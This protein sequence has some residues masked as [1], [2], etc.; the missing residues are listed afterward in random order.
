MTRNLK[1][2]PLGHCFNPHM[3]PV[4][5]RTRFEYDAGS[6]FEVILLADGRLDVR[7]SGAHSDMLYTQHHVGNNLIV[8]A[9]RWST[10]A[11]RHVE[12]IKP[13]PSKP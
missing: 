11:G 7:T 10:E 13:E 12:F 5:Y 2:Y 1:K 4:G 6:Y 9:R 3:I 8:V